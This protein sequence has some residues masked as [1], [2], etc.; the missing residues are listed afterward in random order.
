MS[1]VRRMTIDYCGEMIAPHLTHFDKDQWL[2]YLSSNKD[3]GICIWKT[4]YYQCNYY[5]DRYKIDGEILGKIKRNRHALIL[6]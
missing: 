4:F 2:G 1:P 6:R 5:S 3:M